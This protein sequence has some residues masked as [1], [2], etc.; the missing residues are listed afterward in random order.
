MIQL[1]SQLCQIIVILRTKRDGSRV[2]DYINVIINV[3]CGYLTL[4]ARLVSV[5]TITL[6]GQ[7]TVIH[8][9]TESVIVLLVT[10]LGV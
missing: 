7:S 6:E 3:F 5:V 2:T 8:A 9:T 10:V 1:D 4:V